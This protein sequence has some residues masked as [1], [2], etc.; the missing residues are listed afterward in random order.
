MVYLKMLI[1]T[2]RIFASTHDFK[3]RDDADDDDVLDRSISINEIMD[4]VNSLNR[5]K[6]Y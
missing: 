4:A 2:L 1:M 3:C 6:A 5:G